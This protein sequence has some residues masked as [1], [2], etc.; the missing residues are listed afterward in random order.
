VAG[1]WRARRIIE[2]VVAV[3]WALGRVLVLDGSIQLTERFE[4]NYH[5]A[6]A[7]LPLNLVR[8]L[9]ITRSTW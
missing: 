9:P 1:T 8:H 2:C 6:L 4:S 3:R 7:H 5:E